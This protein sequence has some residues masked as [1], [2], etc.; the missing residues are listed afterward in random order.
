MENIPNVMR[1][2]QACRIYRIPRDRLYRAIHAKEL[3]VGN[4]GSERKAS[5]F[6]FREDIETWLRGLT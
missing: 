3:P 5:F 6:L 2:Q 4:F 1:V